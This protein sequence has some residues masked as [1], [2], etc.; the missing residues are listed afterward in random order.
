MAVVEG[1][2]TKGLLAKGIDV[3]T[4]EYD[5]AVAGKD[6]P[7]EPADLVVCT[8]VLEHIEPDCLD[9][10]LSDLARL[11]KK[12]LLVNISTRPAVKVL[13]DGSQRPHSPDVAP[14]NGSCC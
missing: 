8:D 7:P 3:V 12:V 13:A 1:L 6:L 4:S 5:P 10:V 9:D 11:T 2:L 14:I